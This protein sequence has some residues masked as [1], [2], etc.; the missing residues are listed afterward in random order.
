MVILVKLLTVPPGYKS[1]WMHY[2]LLIW[3]DAE[4]G[5]AIFCSSVAALRPL[6]RVMGG[7][8]LTN[9]NQMSDTPGDNTGR[10]ADPNV[11][12]QLSLSTQP[13]RQDFVARG[14]RMP[15]EEYELT[16]VETLKADRRIMD[17]E[18]RIRALRIANTGYVSG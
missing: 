13:K 17:N 4:L 9:L 3:A 14:M 8:S 18:G 11:S 10:T 12:D 6:L 16:S 15:D 1:D 2:Q 5:L 7:H